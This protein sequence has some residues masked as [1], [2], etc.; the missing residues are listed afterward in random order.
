MKFRFALLTLPLFMAACAGNTGPREPGAMQTVS[1][2]QGET[3]D[4]VARRLGV[5]LNALVDANRLSPPYRLTTGETLIVPVPHVYTVQSGDSLSKIA[6]RF[7]ISQSGIAR[8]NNMSPPYKV[9]SGQQLVLPDYHGQDPGP[10]VA[11]ADDADLVPPPPPRPVVQAT[12][13]TP[14]VAGKPTDLSSPVA[15]APPTQAAAPAASTDTAGPASGF[16]WPV[17][18][19]IV[20]TFGPKPGGLHN[21]GIN[22]AAAEG[23]PVKA[24]AQGAVAYAGSDLKGFGNLVLIRHADGWITAYA[25]LGS[26][27]VKKGE[28]VKAGQQVG[29]VGQT[30]SIDSPQLHFELRHGKEA[31]DPTGKLS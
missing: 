29:T 24:A 10:Q 3:I 20:S 5:S 8:L 6:Q 12:P 21:D 30:G 19:E 13:L 28:A 14:P 26:I 15:L 1:V 9:L 2:K 11:G 16:L 4:D 31:V 25:H 23:T 27:A 18:G 7:N 17:K 22:I